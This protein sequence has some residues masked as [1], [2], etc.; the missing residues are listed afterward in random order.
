MNTLS[1]IVL[2]ATV[3]ISI[4]IALGY[5]SRHPEVKWITTRYRKAINELDKVCPSVNQPEPTKFSAFVD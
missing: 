3:S 1:L 5:W 2:T 4:G